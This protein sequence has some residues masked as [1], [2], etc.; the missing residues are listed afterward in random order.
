MADAE[1]EQ[2][3]QQQQQQ[4]PPSSEAPAAASGAEL[5]AQ[6][7]EGEC[8]LCGSGNEAEPLG[9]VVSTT[10]QSCFLICI[11]YTVVVYA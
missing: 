3:Q 1:T 4:A 8:A 7:L 2:H 6:A 11:C 9:W 5:H 10:L